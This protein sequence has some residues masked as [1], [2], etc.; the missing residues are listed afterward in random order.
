MPKQFALLGT[1]IAHSKSPELFEKAYH[2]RYAYKLID[3]LL[4]ETAWK[5][6]TDNPDLQAVNITA[7]FKEQAALLGMSGNPSDAR[8]ILSPQVEKIGA[9]NIAVKQ[10]DGRIHL[11]NSDYL[12]VKSILEKCLTQMSGG[13]PSSPRAIVAG[14]GGAG[15]AALAACSELGLKVRALH[16][17][18][19]ADTA[20][21]EN[22]SGMLQADI[23]IYTLP[24]LVPGA[25][26]ICCRYLLEAN[27]KNPCLNN[28]EA[29][30]HCKNSSS[31]EYI[32][33]ETWLYEQAR[34]G[35]KIMTSEV[36]DL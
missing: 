4:F 5:S 9:A 3:E 25:L 13:C 12:A 15:K 26:D 19:L 22:P 18:E 11:Y 36:P 35:Y 6:F 20:K 27:Y 31:Y 10:A 7:P 24:C 28:A 8:I 32:G 14:L 21:S 1:D 34:L 2:G 23:V 33:G 17:N 30:P 29:L 16:H